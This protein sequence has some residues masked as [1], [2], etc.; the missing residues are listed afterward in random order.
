M[1]DPQTETDYVTAILSE[2]GYNTETEED[3]DDF[4]PDTTDVHD[5]Y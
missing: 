1:Y 5:I 3:Y 4:D 2:F